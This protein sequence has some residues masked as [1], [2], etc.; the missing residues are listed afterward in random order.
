MAV[1]TQAE[2]YR[3]IL[4]ILAAARERLKPDQVVDLVSDR[5]S[6]SDEER[7]EKIQSGGRRIKKGLT[8]LRSL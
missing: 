2:L 7:Q 1:P 4:E 6:L 3:P 5:F 8:G